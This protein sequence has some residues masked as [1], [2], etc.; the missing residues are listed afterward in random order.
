M[1]DRGLT[2]QSSLSR[3]KPVRSPSAAECSDFRSAR[4]P[5]LLFDVP[6]GS[7]KMFSIEMTSMMRA[8]LSSRRLRISSERVWSIRDHK[9]ELDLQ[10]C[11]LGLGLADSAR[12]LHLQSALFTKKLCL[13]LVPELRLMK[14]LL[15]DDQSSQTCEIK[16]PAT[17][18][19]IPRFA[20]TS[21]PTR[22]FPW[23]ATA[24]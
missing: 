13:H 24:G 16:Q 21:L 4:V 22:P 20:A 2:G 15:L 9:S 11:D 14:D 19:P 10:D 5:P 8:S 12:T 18:T 17:P 1:L 23:P 6:A 3:C 7:T